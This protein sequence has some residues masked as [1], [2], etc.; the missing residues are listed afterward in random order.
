M[1]PNRRSTA[2]VDEFLR[3]RIDRRELLTRA[4]ALGATLPVLAAVARHGGFS[5]AAQG[6]PQAGG[7]NEPQGP[8][9]ENLVLWT[10]ASP[11]DPTSEA[12][13]SLYTQLQAVATAYQEKIGTTV[14]LVT[15]PNDDFRSRM[16]LAAPGGEG[17]DVFGPVAHDWIGEFAVQQIALA[18]PETAIDGREDFIP[19]GLD[20]STV[21][22]TLYGLP[23]FLESVA[24]I[25]NT[26]LIPTP[27][28]TWD[29]LVAA[30][31]SVTQGDVYGLGFPLLEQYHEGGF[32]HGFGGYI[33]G[34]AEG[35]FNIE[36]IGL[37]NAGSFEAAKFLRDMFHQQQPPLPEVAI[38]RSNMHAAIDAMQEA[39]QIGM[40]INGP[41]REGSLRRA[42]INYAVAKLPTLPNGQPMKPFA[43]VQAM[44][45]NAYGE[46]QDAA[47][48]F[49]RFAT[50]TD[51][52][53][54]LYRADPKPV[55]RQSAL[56]NPAV[57]DSPTIA[58][59]TEQLA[60]TVPMPNIPAMGRVWTPWG[61]AMDAIIPPNASDEE[62]QG[63][64]DGAVE[65]IREAIEEFQ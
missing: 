53:V 6:T 10:R 41:W 52:Q 64:L 5:T 19:V 18:I 21:D 49:L 30:A 37:N 48:D 12:A 44:M 26:D 45:A 35:T 29:E 13:P 38:D 23:V 57:A 28:A 59:W 39:G 40:M 17:P 15:V 55:A 58:A 63:L 24:L 46:Q 3:G 1:M 4:A 42:G 54:L 7:G 50:G 60:D 11:D 34:Y 14:E 43:G 8:Q 2:L 22:G 36:D 47:L 9:V 56:A 20:L 51:S 16:S 33:F 62:V 61:A 65:Q 27:P 31:T 25:Y 32:F